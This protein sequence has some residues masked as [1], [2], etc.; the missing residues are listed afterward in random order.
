[1]TA[2]SPPGQRYSRRV[3]AHKLP[4]F[5]RRAERDTNGA[6][7][8]EFGVVVPMLTLMVIAI[9]DIGLGVHRK[10]QVEDA[11]QAGAEWA[12]RNGFDS[13]GIS[14]A[15]TSATNA[16]VIAS[17]APQQF[18]GCAT[19]SSVSTVACGTPCPSGAMAGTYATVSAQLNYSTTLN[20]GIAPS[21]YTFAAQSTVRLQ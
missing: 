5:F 14:N 13:N 9:A 20:Y 7:A 12:I 21:T 18:C 11:A 4:Q 2:I 10:M 17:P 19:G 3:L 15:L 1:M 6:A 16:S 8:I